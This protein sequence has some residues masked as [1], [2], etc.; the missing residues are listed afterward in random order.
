MGRCTR[1]KE[2]EWGWGETDRQTDMHRHR[3]RHRHIGTW[4]H[5]QRCRGDTTMPITTI[6]RNKYDADRMN[7]ESFMTFG[8]GVGT[9]LAVVAAVD[10]GDWLCLS[11]SWSSVLH[12]S[13][14][15][16]H[17]HTFTLIWYNT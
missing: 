5:R 15:E 3:H 1:A 6:L 9:V 16:L 10:G 7:V 14:A 11:K 2:R 4:A 13:V 17:T 12:V 8:V